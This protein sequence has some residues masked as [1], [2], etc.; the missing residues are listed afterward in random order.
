MPDREKLKVSVIIPTLNGAGR[1]EELF[2]S[3]TQQSL[4]LEEILV[5]DSGSHDETRVI[6]RSNGARVITISPDTFDHGGTRNMA[7]REARGDILVYLTQDAILDDS[8]AIE[9]LV[10]PFADARIAAAYGRQL[11]HADATPAARHLRVF[12]YPE[13]GSVRCWKDRETFGFKT[14]FISNSFAAYRREL[15]EEAGF[16]VEGLLFGEDT[17]TLAKLLRR[18]YCV[19]YVADA[20]VRH[21]HNYS[22]GREFRRYFDIGVVHV[23]HRELIASFGTPSA[24]GRQYVR[25][26]LSYLFRKGYFLS[27]PGS[28]MRNGAKFIAYHLGKRYTMLPHGL[29][30]RCSLNKGWWRR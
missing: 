20:R 6:A 9:N 15:L 10:A 25:S 17:F 28:I 22:I 30:Q 3:F 29:A 11:P 21:S 5:I 24:E 23:R 26:E 4:T 16:F 14:A 19:A 2:A 12:N 13:Q 1:L 27:L 18:G 8:K 7:G